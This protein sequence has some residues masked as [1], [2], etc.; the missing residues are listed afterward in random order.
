MKSL[1]TYKSCTDK[2]QEWNKPH[3]KRVDLIPVEKLGSRHQ[4]LQTDKSPVT[5]SK[6]VFD[7][8][9]LKFQTPNQ[10]NVE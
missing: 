4:K 3:G 9:P 8:R 2:L 1:P 5:G 7:S 6:M 10:Q